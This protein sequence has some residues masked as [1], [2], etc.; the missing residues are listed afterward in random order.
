M[1]GQGHPGSWG[2]GGVKGRR[3]EELGGGGV[4][5]SCTMTVRTTK[6]PD[7]T[8]GGPDERI[9]IRG[10]KLTGMCVGGGGGCVCV[11]GGAAMYV[12]V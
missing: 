4:S 8:A 12:S 3:E 6:G 7:G 1:D 5:L 11:G 2:G 9:V 10:I